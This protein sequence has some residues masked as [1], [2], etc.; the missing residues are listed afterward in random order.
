MKQ[1]R[2]YLVGRDGRYRGVEELEHM[3]DEAAIQAIAARPGAGEMELWERGR[4]VK[5]FAATRP[6]PA[7]TDAQP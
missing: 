2:L 6:Q 3:D 7:G 5:S 4:K 1:Y